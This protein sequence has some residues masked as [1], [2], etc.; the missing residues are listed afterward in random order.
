M[1]SGASRAMTSHGSIERPRRRALRTLAV[2]AA[3]A[4]AVA[5]A[6]GTARGDGKKACVAAS[7]QAQVLRDAGKLRAAR[8]QFVNC[9][10]SVC[11]GVVR[12]FCADALASVE[13]ATPSLVVR[14]RSGD[15]V[16]LVDVAVRIDGVDAVARLDGK[17]IDVD[18][19]EHALVF[20][21]GDEPPIAMRVLVRAGE[22]NRPVDVQF[23]A[24]VHPLSPPSSTRVDVVERPTPF[25]AYVLGA[26]G[27]VAFGT[28]AYFAFGARSDASDLRASCGPRCPEGS[29]DPVDRKV[30]IA[31]IALVTGLA[32]LSGAV[33]VYLVRPTV[34]HEGAR[35]ALTAAP[36]ALGAGV[37]LVGG[38]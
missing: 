9:A 3:V 1:T 8:E 33:I 31:N 7:D 21:H 13:A 35:L 28:A 2:V 11:P 37:S 10:R 23:V 26:A 6:H 20:T 19:G 27:L 12:E 18:P 34:H 32:A 30:R 29:L 4:F 5:F 14:A 25:G 16:D 15:D 36:S 22:K 24:R 17:P 38:F